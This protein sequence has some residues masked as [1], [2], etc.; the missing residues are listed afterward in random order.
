MK[1]FPDKARLAAMQQR[2]MGRDFGWN[3]AAAA[4]ERLYQDTL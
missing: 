3:A 4:Y 2:G 1:V